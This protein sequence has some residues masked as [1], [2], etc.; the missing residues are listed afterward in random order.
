MAENYAPQVIKATYP[1]FAPCNDSAFKQCYC[2][3]YLTFYL[4]KIRTS[5]NVIAIFFFI[6][7]FEIVSYVTFE[8]FFMLCLERSNYGI[9]R[10]ISYSPWSCY[11]RLQAGSVC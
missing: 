2:N 10:F 7:I 1:F 5:D 9:Y 11:K 4:L 8:F 6:W 3:F